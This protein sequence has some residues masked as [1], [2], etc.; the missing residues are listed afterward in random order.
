[1]RD[2]IKQ[3]IMQVRRGEVPKGYQKT[4]AGIIPKQWQCDRLGKYI[5]NYNELSNDVKHLPVVTSSRQGLLLQ[6]EYYTEERLT[7]K[8]RGY[9]VVPRGYVTYRHMSDDHIFRFNL[10][11]MADKV[12][13]SPEYP[14]FCTTEKMNLSLLVLH[15]NTS[16]QFE[17]FCQAQKKG[18]TRT[19]MYFKNLGQYILPVPPIVEQQK[20]TEILAQCDKVISLK[21]E[22]LK[23]KR[24]QK[25]WMMQ[26]LLNSDSG[27][28]LPGFQESKWRTISLLE[29]C[30]CLDVYRK[31]VNAK[32][33]SKMQGC[34]PY[35][36]ANSIQD[37]ISAYLFDE[38]I[39]LLAEDGGNFD[40][41]YNKPIALYVDEKCWVN[42]HA[43]ILRA[44]N[45]QTKFLFYTLEHKDIR[46]FINGT[47]R[48]KLTQ[49]DMLSI[50]IDIPCTEKEQAAI[51]NILFTADKEIDLLEQEL[52]LWKEK[53]KSLT[54]LLLTGLVRI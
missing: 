37:Y 43:H 3:R 22:L 32:N 49:S 12:L 54:Q 48:S 42:N 39:V 10:N 47:T 30:D 24:R 45:R 38:E 36:G 16:R 33:R 15:L 46:A 29:F 4:Q 26:E 11:T 20:I 7:E 13:V 9:H 51:A 27:V 17:S 5:K 18:S 53:K 40:D 28:R 1:M 50:L 8:G 44:K 2:T 23:E 35:Y 25:K 52:A 31:P 6:S 21:Q 34:Y 41:F 14:V 19:R